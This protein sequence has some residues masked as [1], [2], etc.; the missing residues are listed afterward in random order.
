MHI[1]W[2]L[3]KGASVHDVVN[4]IL[5]AHEYAG[6]LE[7]VVI[8]AHGAP[9]KIYAG[10]ASR[11]PIKRSNVDLFGKVRKNIK[12]TIWVV[13]CEVACGSKGGEFGR[14]LARAADCDV[15]ASAWNQYVETPTCP[16]G[17]IDLYEK[18]AFHWEASGKVSAH[19]TDGAGVPGVSK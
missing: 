9:G 7:N 12:G 10:G 14:A 18:S 4:M 15:V 19:R 13:A 5:E 3:P 8:N 17:G 16:F 2:T 6:D 11:S 1:S